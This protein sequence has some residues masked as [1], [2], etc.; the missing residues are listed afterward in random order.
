[1]AYLCPQ[2]SKAKQK[3]EAAAVSLSEEGVCKEI[4]SIP[5][6]NTLVSVGESVFMQ[7]ARTEVKHPK[8]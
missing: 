7:T 6:E 4:R 8:T 3:V 1:M 5:G 2:K